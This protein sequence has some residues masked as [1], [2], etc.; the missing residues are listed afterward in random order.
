MRVT[1]RKYAVMLVHSFNEPNLCLADYEGDFSAK[2]SDIFDNSLTT[3]LLFPIL[4][5]ASCHY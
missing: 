5:E 1:S 4:V 2:A 3:S